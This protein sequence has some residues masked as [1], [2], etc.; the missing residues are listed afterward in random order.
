MQAALFAV[1]PGWCRKIATREKTIEVRKTAPKLPTPYKGY[2]Y[3]TKR[4]KP[5]LINLQNLPETPYIITAGDHSRKYEV[6][7]MDWARLCNGKVWAEFICDTDLP[8]LF[9]CSDPAAL[10]THYEVPGTCLSDVE[11]M[12]YLGN[13]KEGH[14]LHISELTI[15]DKPREL[16]EFRRVCVNGLYCESCAMYNAHTEICGNAALYLRRP[17]QSWCYVEEI[18]P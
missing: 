6:P 8:L 10:V 11:I 2:L 17:P 13:G 5:A 4:Q 15:Y 9:E 18:R 16:S 14:G 3:C 12:D 7:D 1:R